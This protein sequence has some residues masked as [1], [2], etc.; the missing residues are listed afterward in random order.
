LLVFFGVGLLGSIIGT[1][2]DKQKEQQTQAAARKRAATI[3]ANPKLAAAERAERRKREI[4]RQKEQRAAEEQERQAEIQAQQAD[5]LHAQRIERLLKESFGHPGF[6]PSWYLAVKRRYSFTE[7]TIQVHTNLNYVSS[8]H[9]LHEEWERLS[10]ATAVAVA[11]YIY[12]K[13]NPDKRFK[14]VEVLS[15]EGRELASFP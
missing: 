1:F 5:T 11:D 8:N 10:K 2:Q 6:E 3:A 4:Q 7:D 15:S 13:S 14:Q 9:P 12:D